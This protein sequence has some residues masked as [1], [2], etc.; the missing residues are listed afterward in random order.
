MTKDWFIVY[1][2]SVSCQKNCYPPTLFLNI[3]PWENDQIFHHFWLCQDAFVLWLKAVR[4]ALNTLKITDRLD[5]TVS[6]HL[7]LLCLPVA[8]SGWWVELTVMFSSWIWPC[9]LVGVFLV[10]SFVCLAALRNTELI[11]RE[12]VAP[13]LCLGLYPFGQS[14]SWVTGG[15]GGTA[16]FGVWGRLG[17]V[18]KRSWWGNMM[19][20]RRMEEDMSAGLDQSKREEKLQQGVVRRQRSVEYKKEKETMAMGLFREGRTNHSDTVLRTVLR[21]LVHLH[22]S[23]LFLSSAL[24]WFKQEHTQKSWCLLCLF[25]WCS[26][27]TR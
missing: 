20:E 22:V 13:S 9:A 8:V 21:T 24:K 19:Q 4:Y 23:M 25:W 3:F 11:L 2:H 26:N 16:T 1:F 7:Q 6:Q 27:I 5:G 14:C 10:A 18:G 12:Q 17:A 15:E